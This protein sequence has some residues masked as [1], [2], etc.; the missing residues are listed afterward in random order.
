M[1]LSVLLNITV[2]IMV[3][4]IGTFICVKVFASLYKAFFPLKEEDEAVE[5][6]EVKT[7]KFD[8]SYGKLN[9][10]RDQE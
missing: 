5:L 3:W 9:S 8:A 2:K 4:G 7:E 10:T 1:D 6:D